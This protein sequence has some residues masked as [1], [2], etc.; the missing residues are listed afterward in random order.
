[1][2][3]LYLLQSQDALQSLH[4]E[5]DNHETMILCFMAEACYDWYKLSTQEQSALA[6]QCMV[7]ALGDDFK[8]RSLNTGCAQEI[9]WST[10]IELTSKH[11][12]II[13]Y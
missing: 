12:H 8:Q 10:L 7:F 2:K 1:M 6:E 13:T 9:T 4:I 11:E 3:T 5:Q